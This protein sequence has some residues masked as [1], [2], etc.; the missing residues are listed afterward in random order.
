MA[1]STGGGTAGVS[2]DLRLGRRRAISR[3]RREHMQ[4]VEPEQRWGREESL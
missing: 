3:C 4:G 1:D 2:S